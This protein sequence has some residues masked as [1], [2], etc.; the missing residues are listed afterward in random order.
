MAG[1][2]SG[3]GAAVCGLAYFSLGT[4]ADDDSRRYLRDY[5][6]F[7]G[8]YAEMIAEGASVPRPRS[9]VPCRRSATRES[10]SCSF[11]PTTAS[12]D[13]IDRLADVVL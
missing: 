13:Q 5:Y 11:D 2:R 10:P 3:R 1:G 12:L 8:D 4:D 9:A 6:G 7:L